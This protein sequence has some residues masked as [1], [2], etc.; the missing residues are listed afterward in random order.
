MHTAIYRKIFKAVKTSKKFSL[1]P[2]KADLYLKV[3]I[4]PMTTAIRLERLI[5]SE[6]M[7]TSTCISKN[8]T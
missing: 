1:S 8:D 7:V 3:Y 5:F 6:F 4:L 2:C